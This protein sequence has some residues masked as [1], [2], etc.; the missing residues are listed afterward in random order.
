MPLQKEIWQ[1]DI[2]DNLY[3]GNQF[4]NI[5]RNGDQYVLNGAIVHIP[6][7]G[8]A[9]TVKRNITTFPQVAVQ[10]NDSEIIYALD[11]YYSLPRHVQKLEQY[12][13]SYDKRMSVVGD[14]IRNLV[15]NTMNGLL[16]RWAPSAAGVIETTGADSAADLISGATGTRKLFT[17][18]QFKLIAKRFANT[19]I[20]GRKVA[21]LTANHYHQLFESFSDA[22]KTNFNNVADLANG[23][24]G[25]YMGIDIMM[26]SS[27]LRYRKVSTVWTPVDTL[28]DGYAAAAG[29]SA[30]SLFWIDSCVERALGSVQTFDDTNNPQYYGDLYSAMLRM[31]GRIVRSAGVIAVVE[32]IGA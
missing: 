2:I 23:I 30:A 25:R 9:A 12:E 13:L 4:A 7:S 10:R 28:A 19:D 17:K 22:E 32:A 24:V 21:L 5:A 20:P 8:A 15:H 6:V 31:G 18:D 1:A 29:D 16:Y 27:V 14:D 3:P 26:R 11:T